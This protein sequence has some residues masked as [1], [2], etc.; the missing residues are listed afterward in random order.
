MFLD[1]V[2]LKEFYDLPMGRMLRVLINRRV[3]RLWP[4]IDGHSL[5]GLGYTGPF[6][7]PY[8]KET[9]RIFA[10]MP[11][12]QGVVKW[13]RE[14]HYANK[15]FLC[16]SDELPLPDSSIDRIIL[17][18]ALDMSNNPTGLLNEVYRVLAPGG[19]IIVIVPNRRGIWA[20]SEASPFGYGTPY[21]RSQL[22]G[23]LGSH[24][25]KV[26][27]REEALYLPP[28]KSKFVLR[29]A[30]VFERIGAVI[31]SSFAGLLV[32]E[33]EK[34]VYRGVPTRGSRVA[35]VLRPVF[36]PEGKPVGVQAR[37]KADESK[38]QQPSPSH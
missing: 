15:A 23:L 33:A 36:L 30:R 12:A 13:P 25:L 32:L 11:A 10:G 4:E 28:T 17:V 21:S 22:E 35:R 3:R 16:D 9:N 38:E 19:R 29:N 7:R 26:T 31:G 5:L 24:S 18:H 14:S 37:R 6:L 20:Q 34:Q 2:H 8:L 1:V 27:A